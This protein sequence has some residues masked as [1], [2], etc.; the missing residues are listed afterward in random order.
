MARPAAG[1]VGDP[2]SGAAQSGQLSE[3]VRVT[4]RGGGKTME[5]LFFLGK[6]GALFGFISSFIVSFFCFVLFF[7]REEDEWRPVLVVFSSGKI[8]RRVD[9][10]S[11]FP[12]YL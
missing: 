7:G 8:D 11:D 3:W 2:L 1:N 10:R 9:S 6:S 4:Q 12:L 5:N